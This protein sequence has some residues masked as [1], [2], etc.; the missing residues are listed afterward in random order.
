MGICSSCCLPPPPERHYAGRSY[1]SLESDVI[2]PN[3]GSVEINNP[4]V[5]RT[6]LPQIKPTYPITFDPT[7][8]AQELVLPVNPLE[9]ALL[10][11]F[12]AKQGQA[13]HASIAS[14]ALFTQKLL[15]VGAPVEMVT[16]S[17]LCANEEVSHATLAFALASAYQGSHIAPNTYDSHKVSVSAD[18]VSLFSDTVK[19]GC[20]AETYAALQAAKDA[21][22]ATDPVVCAVWSKIATDEA[23]HASYAWRVVQW[24]MHTNPS[25]YE[26]LLER[27]IAENVSSRYLDDEHNENV[28]V[29]KSLLDQ[30][31]VRWVPG[32]ALN[33]GK[34]YDQVL[35][36]LNASVGE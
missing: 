21:D 1:K 18:L 23:Y 25:F 17:L 19:E 24:V 13:E 35:L 6:T 22:K 14:F 34:D 28:T 8:I 10:A 7:Y 30:M 5:Q 33:H 32:S 31:L 11:E 20:I 29:I 27:L 16:E 26:E 12:W 3:L 9:R 36:V 15:S 2:L 4:F